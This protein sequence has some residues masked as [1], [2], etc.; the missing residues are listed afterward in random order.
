MIQVNIYG[1]SDISQENDKYEPA[2]DAEISEAIPIDG[3]DDEF[4]GLLTVGL[5]QFRS[6]EY[7]S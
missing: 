4:T 5:N 1:W 6:V 7:G 3:D 2:F